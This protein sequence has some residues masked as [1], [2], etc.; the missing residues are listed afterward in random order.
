MHVSFCETAGRRRRQIKVVR[1]A[2]ENNFTQRV[3]HLCGEHLSCHKYCIFHNA[4]EVVSITD[5]NM[6]D[7][8]KSVLLRE[9][10]ARFH[11][12]MVEVTKACNSP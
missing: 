2:D 10:F 6:S 4:S 7:V 1:V 5:W 9:Y 8:Y 12:S 3:Q 11:W